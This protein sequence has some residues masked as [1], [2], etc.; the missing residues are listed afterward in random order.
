MTNN[1]A[2]KQDLQS[3]RFS[4]LS[5]FGFALVVIG[6]FCTILSFRSPNMKNSVLKLIRIGEIGVILSLIGGLMF[7]RY[8]YGNQKVSKRILN[9]QLDKKYIEEDADISLYRFHLKD[10]QI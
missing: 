1:S 3:M 10:S 6:L 7:I 2:V 9:Q 8:F 5:I 4:A